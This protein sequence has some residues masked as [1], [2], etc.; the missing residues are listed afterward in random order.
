MPRSFC[1]IALL[2]ILARLLFKSGV[3]NSNFSE[4]QMRSYKVTRGPHYDADATVVASDL[5]FT[6][7]YL[8]I[9]FLSNCIVSHRELISSLLYARIK[10]IFNI[11]LLFSRL[12]FCVF[13]GVF[14]FL[15]T[16]DIHD[17]RIHY[18]FLTF[19]RVLVS[20]FPT[21]AG[22]SLSAKFCPS[23]SNL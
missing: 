21:V 1:F 22:R 23:G 16:V 7:N 12:F 10:Q 4:G 2:M 9:L 15:V 11:L 18:H 3:S 6:R 17:F 5:N 20:A 14:A 19:S 13:R 8:Y